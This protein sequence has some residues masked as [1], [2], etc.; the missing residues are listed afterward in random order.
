MSLFHSEAARASL[1]AWYPRF[2]ARVPV[3][4]AERVLPTRHGDTHVL[5]AGPEAAPPLVVLHGALA[6]SAHVLPEL[7]PLLR[8][9]RVY[10]VDVLGQS[11]QSADHRPPI[12]G[13]AY[14][15][16][17]ADVLDGLD[18]AK[19]SLLGVSWGGF[20]ATRA[21]TTMP[22]RFD[23]L[24]LVV[25]AGIVATPALR[26]MWRL[27]LPLA[28][29]TL[30]RHRASLEALIAATFTTPDA[31]WQTYMA[32]AFLAYKIDFAAPPPLTAAEAAGWKGPVLV[33]GATDDLSFPGDLV[34]ARSRAL[35][36]Q[37][38]TERLVGSKHSPATDPASRE[39][40]CARVE[41][42][43]SRVSPGA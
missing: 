12:A 14:Q 8:T 41:A 21:A 20:V 31:D 4:T 7:G 38:D 24:V 22:G 17:L 6:T 5:V 10:A 37:V 43:L 19:T 30:V 15:E 33:F 25:P 18:L 27:G 3:P 2:L 9:R 11:T 16:W 42:F 32:E 34:L 13:P 40:L 1:A 26:A 29:W 35:W 28:G 36:P 39:A 23:A